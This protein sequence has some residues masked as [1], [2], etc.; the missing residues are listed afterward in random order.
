MSPVRPRGARVAVAGWALVVLAITLTPVSGSPGP[1]RI[2]LLCGE[3]GLA[4]AVLNV[5]MFV[6]FGFV[7]ARSG[8][9]LRAATLAAVAVSAGIEAAQ[10]LIPGRIGNPGD[11]LFNGFGGLLG[12]ALPRASRGERTSGGGRGV[13]TAAA[14][15]L[16]GAAVVLGTGWMAVTRAPEGRYFG[17]WTPELGHL[18]PTDGTILGAR[19]DGRDVPQ[20]W[21]DR[22][23]ALREALDRGATLELDL[24]P[25]T[26]TPGLAGLFA[27]YDDRQ[28]E[29]LLVGRN[30]DDLVLRWRRRGSA[31][32]LAPPPIV[33][34]GFFASVDAGRPLTLTVGVGGRSP[35]PCPE[36]RPPPGPSSGGCR[37]ALTAG[38]GWAFLVPL[39]RSPAAADL[40]DATWLA[41]LGL[42]VGWGAGTGRRAV[43]G[44]L[45]LVGALLLAPAAGP[46]LP[47][48]ATLHAAVLAGLAAG[49]AFRTRGAGTALRAR[50]PGQPSRV[51][52]AKNSEQQASIRS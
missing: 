1:G 48:S 13:G 45:T 17:F 44:G 10:L 52:A 5:A 41:A 42:L 27:L 38:R 24:L 46:L 36:F 19:L 16:L 33:K 9:S 49:V 6:P 22:S 32:R 15:A 23:S 20:G 35:G 7:L 8:L 30:G 50:G 26:E 4:D 51:R 14:S 3:R 39:P 12:A 37:A 29:A 31:W 34:S 2:C 11:V 28:R 40:A 25:G 18:A 21:S 47:A 43:A